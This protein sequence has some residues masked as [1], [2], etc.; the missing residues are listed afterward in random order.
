MVEKLKRLFKK[1]FKRDPKE[2]LIV[3]ENHVLVLNR[4]GKKTWKR[5]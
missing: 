5:H 4:G 1:L 2:K 3:K